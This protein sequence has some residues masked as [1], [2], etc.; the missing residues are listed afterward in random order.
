[1]Y[2]GSTRLDRPVSSKCPF[3]RTSKALSRLNEML[4]KEVQKPIKP[5]LKT[6]K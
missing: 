1:M 5:S 2:L 4:E 6:K 3:R